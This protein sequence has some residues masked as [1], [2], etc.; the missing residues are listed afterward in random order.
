M[1][2][3]VP[4][5]PEVP[6]RLKPRWWPGLLFMLL[7]AIAQIFCVKTVND[8]LDFID[9]Y[10]KAM[11]AKKETKPDDAVLKL[12]PLLRI[13]PARADWDIQRLLLAN[14]VH[15]SVPHLLV[16]L[17]GAMAGALLCSTFLPFWGLL[18]I[19]MLGG[20]LGLWASLF[21]TPL[22]S[23]YIP[24]VGSSAGIFALMGSYYVFNF[25]YRT[26]YF[27][28]FPTQRRQLA[29]KTSWFFFIDV[30]LIEILLSVGQVFPN[31][32]DTTDH[33]A[34]VVGFL[35]GVVLAIALR[36]L[37]RW[38][39]WIHTQLEWHQFRA[40]GTSR[41]NLGHYL[42]I[43]EL[44]PCNDQAKLF[45]LHEFANL[46]AEDKPRFTPKLFSFLSPTFIR[47]E[48]AQVSEAVRICMENF[49]PLPKQWLKRLPYDSFIRL[50]RE[51]HPQFSKDQLESFF[52][53]FTEAQPQK[54]GVAGKLE[55]LQKR[56]ILQDDSE[57][58][59]SNQ[60]QKGIV[61]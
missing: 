50:L 51:L 28:W 33:V 7:L 5:S 32:I 61:N 31:R 16:N 37:L 54:T 15:G 39:A 23:E 55:L 21:I 49:I 17:V 47:L 46:N 19:Y 9:S 36:Q 45:A 8:D 14:F 56:I 12:R 27:F 11:E 44:N 52:S 18:I 40:F 60:I 48:P 6:Q 34:H 38:P 30:I 10:V 24:H 4:I 43:L 41:C 58:E 13:S 3:F 29:L 53:Q 26:R 1:V 25:R 57:V 42:T 22:G 2:L 59:D 35:S 20:S